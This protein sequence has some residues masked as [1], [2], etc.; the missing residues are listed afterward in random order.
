[1]AHPLAAPSHRAP[2]DVSAGSVRSGGGARVAPC[3]SAAAALVVALQKRQ[4]GD[5]ACRLGRGVSR[6]RRQLR[7]NA[8]RPRGRRTA[9]S[10]S[11]P[12]H[13]AAAAATS[14]LR[15]ARQ[16]VATVAGLGH[17]RCRFGK[18]DGN[19]A[20]GRQTHAA[21]AADRPTG[22]LQ[23]RLARARDA[24]RPDGHRRLDD[25]DER[26]DA[27]GGQR[28][29]HHG[30]E[31]PAHRNGGRAAPACIPARRERHRLTAVECLAPR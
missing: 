15:A 11:R 24:V 19:T 18:A 13:V 20:E 9:R 31:L 4:L 30:M 26:P 21:A 2:A 6:H 12:G 7:R 16:L 5:G 25:R 1:M 14:R 17:Q 28:A 22:R 3:G 8:R 27:A 23:A 10:A 29:G